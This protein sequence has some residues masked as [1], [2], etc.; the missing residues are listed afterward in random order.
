MDELAPTPGPP[1]YAVIFSS[2]R[3]PGGNEAYGA[4]A[5]RMLQLAAQQPGFLGVES[6]RDAEGQGITVSYWQS[7]DAIREWG[8][9]AEHRVAQ[10]KGKR[11]WYE[12]FSLRI[13]RVEH[14][15]FFRRNLSER[16]TDM[17]RQL[18]E[19]YVACGARLREAVNGLSREDLTAR[20]GPGKWSILEVI[21]HLTDSDSISI[22]RMKRILIEDNPPLLYADETAYVDRLFPHEQSLEDAL[23]LFDVGRRQFARVLRKLPDQ[24]FERKGTHNRRG[25][26]AVGE[27]VNDYI[28]HVDHHLKYIHE[29]RAKLGKPLPASGG[30]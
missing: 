18:I 30:R 28:G 26:M 20:P 22:D 24:A 11:E 14:D 6:T 29:K 5:E 4:M 17:N 19:D 23:V 27:L 13:C 21:V 10:Q 9:H 16:R 1:Y 7:L 3:A 8:K 15:D 12:A 25:P 2:Q